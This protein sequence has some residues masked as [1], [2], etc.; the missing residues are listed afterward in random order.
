ME[1]FTS[2]ICLRS[3]IIRC[4]FNFG[5]M[6]VFLAS[7]SILTI[8][9]KVNKR[10]YMHTPLGNLKLFHHGCKRH[11]KWPK[12][13]QNIWHSGQTEH[14]L[15][16]ISEET[17]ALRFLLYQEV[18]NKKPWGCLSSL[19]FP[20]CTWGVNMIFVFFHKSCSFL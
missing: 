12:W 11:L 16:T 9:N 1:L 10:S 15:E 3:F 4:C 5:M 8:F 17:A 19:V 7:A 2:I 14:A 18:E 13:E 6:V 20:Q